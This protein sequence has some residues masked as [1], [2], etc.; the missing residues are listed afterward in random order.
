MTTGDWEGTNVRGNKNPPR[1]GRA[2][3]G[4]RFACVQ[5]KGNDVLPACYGSISWLSLISGGRLTAL[6]RAGTLLGL[7]LLA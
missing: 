7:L 3:E 1:E 2:S 5:F 4:D 6:S